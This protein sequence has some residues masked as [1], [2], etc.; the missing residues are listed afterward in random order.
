[1]TRPGPERFDTV[2]T[3][4][5]SVGNYPGKWA[6]TARQYD[7]VTRPDFAAS[8]RQPHTLEDQTM[9]TAQSLTR[10]PT[11]GRLAEVSQLVSK[12]LRGDCVVRIDHTPRVVD[13]DVRWQQW[14]QTFYAIRDAGPVIDAIV[15][16]RARYPTRTIR[17]CAERLQPQSR[18]VFWV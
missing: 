5:L 3:G 8:R 18:L 11:A 7:I 6:V 1:M 13:R 10:L 15:A 9:Q 14:G 12:Y 16:C 2:N 4:L 17:V